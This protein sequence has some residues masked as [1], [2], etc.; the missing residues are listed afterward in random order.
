MNHPEQY[1]VIQAF[2]GL[3]CSCKLKADALKEKKR[4]GGDDAGV[5]V[6]NR[7]GQN[8]V[9]GQRGCEVR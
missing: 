1:L 2:K 4:L 8:I 7:K 9:E 6:W 3:I 5:W